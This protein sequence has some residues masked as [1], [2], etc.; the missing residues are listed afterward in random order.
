MSIGTLRTGIFL[1]KAAPQHDKFFSL[2]HAVLKRNL[3]L[4]EGHEQGQ[5]DYALAR[6][7]LKRTDVQCTPKFTL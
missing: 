7:S 2:E 1:V 6:A 5:V 4:L 3:K